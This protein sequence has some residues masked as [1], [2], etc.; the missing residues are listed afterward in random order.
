[1]NRNQGVAANR[2]LTS[3]AGVTLLTLLI[4]QVA[5]ALFFALLSFNV[6]LPAGPI[7][8][9]VHPVHFFVGF[10]LFPLLAIKLGSAGYRFAM[11]YLGRPSYRQAGPPSWPARLLAPALIISALVLLVSGIEMWSFRNDLVAYWTQVHMLAAITFV[12]AIILHLLLNGGR[13]HREAAADLAGAS[14]PGGLARRG[15]LAV[16]LIG[17]AGLAVSAANWPLPSLSWL[18]PRRPG[19]GPLDFPV[20]NYE[21]GRQLVDISRWRLR[22]TGTVQRPIALSYG[23]LTQLE[24]EEHEY[25]LNCVTGWSVTRRWQGIPLAALLAKAGANPNFGHVLV[26][27]TSGYHWDHHRQHV[28]LRGA[29]IVTHVEGVPL[30]VDHGYPARLLIPGLQGQSN[31][32]WVNELVVGLG[33]PELYV[34]PNLVPRSQPVTGPLLPADPSARS[35]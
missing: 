17:G 11:Y 7:F 15:L 34:A 3:L 6:S 30:S 23:D 26:R 19:P 9:L 10:L 12:A 13:A 21:G 32:K 14:I 24:T 33:P 22:V 28:L 2:R 25:P 8:D 31:I 20:M 4:A 27:S 35:G 16:G 5:S 1:V 29:L 18:S